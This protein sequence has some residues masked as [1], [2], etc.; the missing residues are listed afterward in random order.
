M[1][2][3]LTGVDMVITITQHRHIQVI[4][5]MTTAMKRMKRPT[6]AL[7]AVCAIVTIITKK[8]AIVGIVN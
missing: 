3:A 6:R 2:Q 5:P 8:I 7:R 4:I 1:Y